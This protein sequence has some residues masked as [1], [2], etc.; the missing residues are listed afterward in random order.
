MEITSGV[1]R[2]SSQL[3]PSVSV[4][5]CT[6]SLNVP[7]VHKCHEKLSDYFLLINATK[8]N[9]LEW[10]YRGSWSAFF[11]LVHFIFRFELVRFIFLKWT[12]SAPHKAGPLF[13]KKRTSFLVHFLHISSWTSWSALLW[14]S[15]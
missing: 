13:S 7:S 12:S 2:K 4:M 15:S 10:S 3:D 8:E 14:G 9:S 1:E 6:K 11:E 5:S